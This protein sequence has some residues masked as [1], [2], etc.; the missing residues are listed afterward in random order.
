MSNLIHRT[1]GTSLQ[2][3]VF[4]LFLVFRWFNAYLTRTYDNP[5]EYWQGQ[6][7]AH[8]LTFGY[9]Y[10]TWEWR[11]RIRSFAHPFIIAFVYKLIQLLGLDNTNFLVFMPRY[12]QS[13]L[14]AVADFAIYS[15]SK[16]IMGN[17]VALPMVNILFTFENIANFLPTI[18]AVYYFVFL[19]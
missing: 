15:L 5:D 6:E 1:S 12:I 4:W 7:I 17:D 14:T 10:L 11:E 3:F 13:S 16:R 2:P 8:Y 9:G 19:V 18:L